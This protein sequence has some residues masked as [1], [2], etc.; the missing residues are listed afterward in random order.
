MKR[1]LIGAALV[2]SFGMG[3]GT[4]FA[5][6]LSSGGSKDQSVYAAP[7]WSGWFAGVNGGVWAASTPDV[8]YYAGAWL[9]GRGSFDSGGGFGGGQI[10]FNWQQGQLV[11]GLE[12]DIQ[13]SGQSEGQISAPGNANAGHGKDGLVFFGTVRGRLG[14]AFGS[15]LLYATGGFAYGDV[16][17]RI[18]L[19]GGAATF[20]RDRTDVGFA[21]CGRRGNRVSVLT[22]MVRQGRVPSNRSW[23]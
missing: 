20:A 2:T 16:S 13:G 10:G 11:Y 4:A 22:R 21:L 15:T 23:Q 1:A 7:D 12:A 3:V 18:D 14:Y 8:N 17:R 5:A 6:D 9:L 19:Y